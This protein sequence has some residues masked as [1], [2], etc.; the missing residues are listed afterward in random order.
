MNIANQTNISYYQQS[1]VQTWGL[2]AQTV[3][4]SGAIALL[5]NHIVY[6]TDL[7][8]KAAISALFPWEAPSSW[9]EIRDSAE[10]ERDIYIQFRQ[11]ILNESAHQTERWKQGK[12]KRHINRSQKL[13]EL[14]QK[15][16]ALLNNINKKI[17]IA[18]THIKYINQVEDLYQYG[19][20]VSLMRFGLNLILP[21]G[22]TLINALASSEI[23]YKRYKLTDELPLESDL[24]DLF[25]THI[26]LQCCIETKDAALGFIK[27]QILAEPLCMLKKA[28][29]DYLFQF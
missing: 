4:S 19:N 20:S 24:R 2:L 18:E 15:V 13:K 23:A 29:K 16:D 28:V 14:N 22:G 6:T 8:K 7:S 11:I 25:L 26:S 10:K 5:R 12:K 1:F 9:S 27:A 17:E 21:E 3:V